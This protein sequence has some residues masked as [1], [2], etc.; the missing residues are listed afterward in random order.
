MPHKHFHDFRRT[1]IRNM[2]RA[3]VPDVVT[4]T[5][6]GHT[7]RAVFDRYNIVAEADQRAALAKVALTQLGHKAASQGTPPASN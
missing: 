6:S 4:M 2:S 3:G 7:T 1:A 5:I